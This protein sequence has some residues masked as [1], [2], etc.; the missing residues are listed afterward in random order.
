[1]SGGMMIPDEVESERVENALFTLLTAT[2]GALACRHALNPAQQAGLASEARG[3][4]ARINSY[5]RI[6]N[7]Q[8]TEL[9]KTDCFNPESVRLILERW[10]QW[11][12]KNSP[13]EPAA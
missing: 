7:N 6:A 10:A 1:M 11:V 4:A 3:G 13:E 2:I 8:I 5:V 9:R 12:D